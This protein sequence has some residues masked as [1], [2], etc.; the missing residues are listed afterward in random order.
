MKKVGVIG[1][2]KSGLSASLF[3]QKEGC[4]VFATDD[5][6]TTA[7]DGITFLPAGEL[8]NRV[9]D[10]DFVVISPGVA[11]S[12]PVAVSCRQ[13]SIDVFCDVELAFRRLVG[14]P[15][16][17]A[18]GITGS[19]GKTTTTSLSTH[20]L[21]FCSVAA[22][23]VGNIGKPILT[24]LEDTSKAFV[25]ELSSF[26]LETISSKVLDACCILNITP[27][28][29]D[30]HGTMEEYARVKERIA[31]LLKE[32]G[33]FWGQKGMKG[34]FSFGFDS[35]CDL[36]TDGKGLYRFGKYEAALPASSS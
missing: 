14:H 5:K 33:A 21:N 8:A 2:G 25:V 19:N 17:K 34:A 28:H 11:L 26:Q 23:A 32:G 24:E 15:T 13:H 6:Q 16:L 30:R 29:L 9:R 31:L 18:L 3:L 7:P 22:E 12:H 27:N 1:L 10:L 20:I 4:T 36:Y 35:S